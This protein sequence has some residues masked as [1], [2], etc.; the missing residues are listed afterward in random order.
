MPKLAYVACKVEGAVSRFICHAPVF[1][2][3]LLLPACSEMGPKRVNE[4]NAIEEIQRLQTAP[5]TSSGRAMIRAV[6]QRQA[7]GTFKSVWQIDAYEGIPA[8]SELVRNEE[9]RDK[10]EILLVLFRDLDYSVFI[11]AAGVME[12]KFGFRIARS[13]LTASERIDAFQSALAW[14]RD[15][16]D[17]LKWNSL[18][19]R[20]EVQN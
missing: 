3:M 2:L 17:K 11:A 10:F 8:I 19:Q 20:F 15:N 16:R 18:N 4:F 14:W 7:D 9:D 1:V 6:P 12:R 5:R 13:P